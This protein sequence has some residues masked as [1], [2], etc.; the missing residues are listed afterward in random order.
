MKLYF[1]G[2]GSRE[3]PDRVLILMEEF[4]QEAARL[5]LILRSGGAPGADQAFERGCDRHPGDKEIFIP[6]KGFENRTGH[7]PLPEA[8]DLAARVHPYYR[9]M[10]RPSKLLVSRN[11]HQIQG[12]DLLTPC[13]FV[14][15]WTKDGCTSHLTYSPTST[16]GTGSAIALASLNNIPVY[17]LYEPQAL[18]NAYA[19]MTQ[20]IRIRQREVVDKNDL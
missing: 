14:L 19:F 1:A 13:D 2:I 8:G 11:M 20:T 18:W 3:T 15:C 9:N 16:G 17:N 5:D 12:I 7:L 10:K 6:W 4:A